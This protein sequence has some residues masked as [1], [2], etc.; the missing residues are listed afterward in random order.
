M[1]S[2]KTELSRSQQKDSW[3][4]S[5]YLAIKQNVAKQHMGQRK[6]PKRNL[7]YFELI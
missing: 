7:K 5:K 4:I 2:Q 6:C 1:H 3:K